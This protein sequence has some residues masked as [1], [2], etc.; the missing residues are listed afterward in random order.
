[1]EGFECGCLFLFARDIKCVEGKKAMLAA[2]ILSFF[3]DLKLLNM[4]ELEYSSLK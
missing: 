3:N 4:V 2:Y 1:M